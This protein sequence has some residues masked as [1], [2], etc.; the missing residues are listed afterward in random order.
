MESRE[1]DCLISTGPFGRPQALRRA[2][3]PFSTSQTLFQFKV[4]VPRRDFTS[5]DYMDKVKQFRVGTQDAENLF[6]SLII[7]SLQ[8]TPGSPPSNRRRRRVLP[9]APDSLRGT[10]R[11]GRF[12]GCE[13]CVERDDKRG[14][15]RE[16]A[17]AEAHQE[18]PSEQGE[19]GGKRP[20]FWKAFL[21]LV[22]AFR[23]PHGLPTRSLTDEGS[24][25]ISLRFEVRR[26]I[27]IPQLEF[28]YIPG[29]SLDIYTDVSAL[30]SAQTLCQLSS[31]LEYLHSKT[32]SIG[33]RDIKPGNIL[34][35]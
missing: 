24:R 34:G 3:T 5:P 35:F 16:V 8:G 1:S 32:P 28:E 20:K 17:A 15:C 33:H 19:L 22:L 2:N 23:R 18:R 4:I 7:R 21:T 6:A 29:G 25:N 11:Q 26:S 10:T 27:P 30:E 13:L 31:A 12:W 14:V 9:L